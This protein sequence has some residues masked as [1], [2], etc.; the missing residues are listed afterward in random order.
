MVLDTKSPY[1]KSFQWSTGS[2]DPSI[3][4]KKP[5][6]YWFF[7]DYEDC[8]YRDTINVYDQQVVLKDIRDTLVCSP[9]FTLSYD[10]SQPELSYQ[11]TPG[12]I[13]DTLSSQTITKPGDYEVHANNAWCEAVESFTVQIAAQPKIE[14]RIFCTDF[15]YEVN[16]NAPKEVDVMWSNG[17]S[18]ESIGIQIPG[19][20]WL[21]YEQKHCIN[22]DSFN[23]ENHSFDAD[24]G[25]D[26]YF[27][28]PFSQELKANI[29]NAKY[30]WNTG[31]T[32]ERI[33]VSEDQEYSVMIINSSGCE[34]RDTVSLQYSPTLP[35]SLGNDTTICV[36]TPITLA[37]EYSYAEYLWNNGSTSSSIFVR[38]EG[39]YI[40]EA[41]DIHGC[42]FTDTVVIDV[43]PDVLPNELHLPNA[44]SPNNDG[45]NDY[46]PFS[47]ARQLI[48]AKIQIY[49]RWG[50]KVFDSDEAG[51]FSWDG[52]LNG[53]RI[54]NSVYVYAMSYVGCDGKIKVKKGTVTVNY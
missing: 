52:T 8:W 12:N 46:F 23:L 19:N 16:S 13:S 41:T 35:F 28:G 39:V 9:K 26:L 17:S 14:D 21:R 36:S 42:R 37:P 22:Y 15:H 48:N 25:N 44:F 51:S 3:L 24:L 32:T 6:S 10:L 38:H 40:L 11:W 27:C 18:D 53:K 47:E 7:V 49:N 30:L 33:T 1:A 29:P 54:T 20:Y 2:T 31:E 5:G 50:Q 43:S 45:L 4:I 34:D